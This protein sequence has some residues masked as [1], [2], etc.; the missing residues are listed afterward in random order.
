MAVW[1]IWAKG[2]DVPPT[3]IGFFGFF[4]LLAKYRSVVQALE[5]MAD[6][7]RGDAANKATAY[8]RIL[9]SDSTLKVAVL[10]W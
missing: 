6:Y 1:G 2:A 3:K 4:V 8:L 5:R 7:S 9:L 10:A